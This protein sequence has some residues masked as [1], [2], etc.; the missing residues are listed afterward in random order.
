MV[1]RLLV[2]DKKPGTSPRRFEDRINS[3]RVPTR[4]TNFLLSSPIVSAMRPSIKIKKYS[5][6]ACSLP[7]IT[8]NLL[9]AIEKSTRKRIM[10]HH[11]ITT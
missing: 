1:L 3:A 5:K 2:G 11:V 6:N 7:G 4:G 10:R 9:E 8:R